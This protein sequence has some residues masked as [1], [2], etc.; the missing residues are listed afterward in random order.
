MAQAAYGGGKAL[1]YRD[2][3]AVGGSSVARLSSIRNMAQC[4]AGAIDVCWRIG[5]SAQWLGPASQ[6]GGAITSMK[7][8]RRDK[9]RAVCRSALSEPS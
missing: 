2:I 8:R 5:H 4:I 6:L 7:R 9:R 3:G 1:A